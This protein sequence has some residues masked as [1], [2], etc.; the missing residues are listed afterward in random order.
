[1]SFKPSGVFGLQH[2]F[3]MFIVI[4]CIYLIF[5]NL[6]PY[7]YMNHFVIGVMNP[8]VLVDLNKD[9]TV[10]ITMSMYNTTIIAFDGESHKRLWDFVFPSSESY[11]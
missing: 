2:P 7:F 4:I 9:G 11:S 8:P 3:E 5:I 6:Y 10:D 1:M